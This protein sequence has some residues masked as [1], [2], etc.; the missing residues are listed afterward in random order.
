MYSYAELEAIESVSKSKSLYRGLKST[1]MY[2]SCEPCMMCMGAILYERITKIVYAAT[3]QDSNDNYC[4]EM[5]TDIEKK[6]RVKRKL[7]FSLFFI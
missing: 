2:L 6:I 3:L 1:T 5:I 4:P 7:S